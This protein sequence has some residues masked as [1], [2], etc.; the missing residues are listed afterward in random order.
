MPQERYIFNEPRISYFNIRDIKLVP[1]FEDVIV[2]SD[3][4][5]GLLFWHLTPVRCTSD[6]D[7]TERDCF[8]PNPLYSVRYEGG[9]GSMSI[10]PKDNSKGE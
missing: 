5:H 4:K 6:R 9:M 2:A 7:E 10:I 1:Y 8:R 3:F